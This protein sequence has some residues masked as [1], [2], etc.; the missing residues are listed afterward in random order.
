MK[1]MGKASTIFPPDKINEIKPKIN[2]FQM[3]N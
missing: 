2:N 1:N 3:N